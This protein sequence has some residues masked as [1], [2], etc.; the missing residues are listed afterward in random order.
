MS[1]T[2]RPLLF[3]AA[4]ATALVCAAVPPAV[5]DSRDDLAFELKEYSGSYY[6]SWVISKLTTFKVGKKCEAKLAKKDE[7]VIHAASFATSD[8]A[9][10]AKAV[11]GDDWSSIESQSANTPEANRKIVEKMMDDFKSKFSFTISVEGDDCDASGGL[12][13]K[14]YT[15]IAKAVHDYPP[16]SGK[17]FITLNVTAKAKGVTAEVGK[18]GSTFKFTAAR[19]VEAPAWDNEI[20]KAFKRVSKDN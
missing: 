14:Y 20:T 6:K 9:E 18:D 12:W 5:A 16:K 2:H 1:M 7:R 3:F 10:Y 8:I 17:A 13:L 15:S 19:D 11:T 4:A